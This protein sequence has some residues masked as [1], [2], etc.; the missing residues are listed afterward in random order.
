MVLL[1]GSVGNHGARVLKQV[2]L[3]PGFTWIGQVHGT[4]GRH[5]TL[6]YGVGL[7]GKA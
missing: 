1:V 7:Y 3:V 4:M 6:V 2:G 5:R